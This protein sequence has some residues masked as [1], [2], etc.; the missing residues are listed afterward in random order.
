[1]LRRIN[2]GPRSAI[3]FGLICLLLVIQRSIS[4]GQANQ[5]NQ[6]EQFVED[7]VVPSMKTLGTLG[8]EFL[9]IRVHTT[10]LRSTLETPE[11][12]QKEVDSLQKSRAA[13][14][15]AMHTMES[16]I[17]TPQGRP[18]IDTLNV[19]IRAYQLHLDRYIAAANANDR[20]TLATL[21]S[22]DLQPSADAIEDALSDI[23][24]RDGV[25]S[26]FSVIPH[27]RTGHNL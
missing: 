5:L 25:Q 15:D 18:A 24:H 1:M 13:I 11:Q 17:V 16:L 9:S 21:G 20:D 26:K 4:L 3:F 12:K 2:I 8:Q 23:S 14:T 7:N 10:R 6:A 22:G 27:G 19:L